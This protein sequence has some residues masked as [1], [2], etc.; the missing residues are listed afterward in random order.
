LNAQVVSSDF[1]NSEMDIVEALP[2]P[3]PVPPQK[4]A[5]LHV[6]IVKLSYMTSLIFHEVG[7]IG[8]MRWFDYM[9]EIF[10]PRFNLI[11]EVPAT[12]LGKALAHTIDERHI[13]DYTDHFFSSK[14]NAFETVRKWWSTVQ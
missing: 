12:V 11:C 1:E 4:T 5:Q 3:Q 7:A 10:F 6:F 14:M 2:G 8:M 9:N 13:R